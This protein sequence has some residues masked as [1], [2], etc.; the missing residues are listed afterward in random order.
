MAALQ[1]APAA[2]DADDVVPSGHALSVVRSWLPP[3]DEDDDADYDA[4]QDWGDHPEKEEPP[5][6]ARRV[7]R[8]LARSPR[9]IL[10]QAAAARRLGLGAK[11]LSHARASALMNPL[12]R[13]MQRQLGAVRAARLGGDDDDAP[14]A[15]VR[16]G[17]GGGVGGQ[18]HAPGGRGGGKG[19]AGAREEADAA[20]QARLQRALTLPCG[21]SRACVPCQAPPPDS[22]GSEGEQETRSSSFNHARRAAAAPALSKKAK[23]RKKHAGLVSS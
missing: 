17:R 14:A 15:A 6:P 18:P 9:A 16:G 22:D 2:A 23:R 8:W 10:T 19:R 7:R 5:R 12:E 3:A 4:L 13:R 1:R 20:L 11:F 21:L